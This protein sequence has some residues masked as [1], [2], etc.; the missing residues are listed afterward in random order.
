MKNKTI[1]N[2]RNNKKH[3]NKKP[4]SRVSRVSRV[5][6]AGFQKT[7]RSYDNP[8]SETSDV[9]APEFTDF[10]LAENGKKIFFQPG[11]PRIFGDYF[12][13]K[14]LGKGAFGRVYSSSKRDDEK[15]YAVKKIML[16]R[17][18]S[19][20]LVQNEISILQIL[21]PYCTSFVVCFFES[22]INTERNTAFLV[23]EEL[24]GFEPLASVIKDMVIDKEYN[25][26]GNPNPGISILLV[27]IFSNLC[28]GITL[29]HHFGIVHRDIKPDNILVNRVTG[30][31]KFI[32]F[33]LACNINGSS[34]INCDGIVG[35]LKTI[36]PFLTSP[37]TQTLYA[38]DLWS[39]GIVFCMMVDEVPVFMVPGNKGKLYTMSDNLSQKLFALKQFYMNQPGEL[40]LPEKGFASHIYDVN[41]AHYD[42]AIMNGYSTALLRNILSPHI[43]KRRIHI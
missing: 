11:G 40:D 4:V 8:L 13:V 14:L 37:T 41:K 9:S 5:G 20:K 29:L 36:D 3:N 34:K 25:A 33:G 31:T 24:A 22:L 30:K 35:T 38:S 16:V 2:K 18:D 43:N 6:G 23:F 21:A 7:F 39:L 19:L 17:D 10:L 28:K 27:R 1:K 32:D 15:K 26:P 12:A 42:Y